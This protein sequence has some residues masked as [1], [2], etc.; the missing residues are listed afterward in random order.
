[1]FLMLNLIVVNY[2]HRGEWCSLLCI[3]EFQSTTDETDVR[4]VV[5]VIVEIRRVGSCWYQHNDLR[6]WF[7]AFLVAFTNPCGNGSAVWW[8]A[9]HRMTL[10]VLCE[11]VIFSRKI[12]TALVVLIV[13]TRIKREVK[14]IV[15]LVEKV[16]RCRP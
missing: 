4:F 7:A 11:S 1:M 3:A 12:L 15:Q 10:P 6:V 2:Y 5:D 16:L 9:K 8:V 14:L 13:G